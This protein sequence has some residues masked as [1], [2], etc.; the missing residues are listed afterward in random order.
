MFI[1]YLV[2]KDSR[3]TYE[4]SRYY[5]G[6]WTTVLNYYENKKFRV[7]RTNHTEFVYFTVNI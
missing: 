4:N 3:K 6:L 2:L 5:S 7:L 1:N